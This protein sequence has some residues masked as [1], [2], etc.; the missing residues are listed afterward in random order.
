MRNRLVWVAVVLAGIFLG[1]PLGAQQKEG[2]PKP[3]A[4]DTKTQAVDKQLFDALRDV[5]N[6]GRDLF[7]KNGDY[8]GCYRVYQGGLLTARPL[9]THRPDLQKVIE[10][11]FADAEQLSYTHQRAFALRKALDTVRAG[12][13]S[14]EAVVAEG[15]EKIGLPQPKVEKPDTPQPKVEKIDKP[16]TPLKKTDWDRLGGLEN[17]RRIVED[18]SAAIAKDPKV[19]VT[20]NGKVKFTDVQV[21]ALKQKLVEWV[22]ENTGGPLL[23]TGKSMKEAH[24]GMGI[25]NAEFDAFLGHLVA[26]LKKNGVGEAEAASFTKKVE[27]TRP[28]IVE[29]QKTPEKQPEEKKSA[30]KAN[31]TGKV[32]HLGK[33][34]SGGTI[35]FLKE[36]KSFAAKVGDDGSY[37]LK[38]LPVDSYRITVQAEPAGVALPQVYGDPE[39]TPLIV[40]VNAGKN[41]RDF[42]LK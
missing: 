14:G 29:A 5:I 40:E 17:V 3:A 8:S 19:N 11:G 28:D 31:V 6:T 7:N 34:L 32:T 13:K 21:A 30:D 35:T 27:V 37:T 1:S 26:A 18:V 36:K 20:R 2:E 25:T 4:G 15:P 10:K 39:L 42:E 12:L 23:Y 33:P 41:V 22:S 24:Q 38:D 9:L 16:G